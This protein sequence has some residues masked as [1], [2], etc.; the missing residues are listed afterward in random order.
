MSLA[1]NNWAQ[2]FWV[3]LF[4]AVLS[5]VFV[6][7]DHKSRKT[8]ID[9]FEFHFYAYKNKKWEKY[10]FKNFLISRL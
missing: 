7:I 5:N 9:N 3:D 1:L 8:Q 6:F 4:E 2:Y 10:A